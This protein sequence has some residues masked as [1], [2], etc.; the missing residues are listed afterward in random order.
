MAVGQLVL[1]VVSYVLISTGSSGAPDYSMALTFQKIAVIFVP[2]MMALGY[3]LF[4]YQLSRIDPELQLEDK[5][6]RYFA[7]ILVRGAL[8]EIAFFYCCVAAL[9]TGVSLF[10]WIAP[11]V[12]LV[13]LLL[14]PTPEAIA[15]DLRLNSADRSKLTQS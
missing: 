9:V 11:V 6:K 10:L 1:G 2:S 4:K 13:F 12:F 8:F 15:A 5:L 14:R 7:L 3:F